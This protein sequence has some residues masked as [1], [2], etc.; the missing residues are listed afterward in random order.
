MLFLSQIML[1]VLGSFQ[2]HRLDFLLID[3][4]RVCTLVR[5]LLGRDGAFLAGLNCYFKV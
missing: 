5:G 2:D 1:G 4:R 3:L